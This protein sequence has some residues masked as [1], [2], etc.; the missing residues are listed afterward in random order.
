[1]TAVHAVAVS[2]T[3]TDPE[4]AERALREQLVPRVSQAPGLVAGYWTTRGN[5]ALSLFVFESEEAAKRMSAQ[6]EAGVPDGVTLDRIEV[7]E[8][9]AH[10]GG[11]LRTETI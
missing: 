1:V 10:T 6:A 9:V 4:A 7:R 3:I 5:D 8:V 2:L 11:P